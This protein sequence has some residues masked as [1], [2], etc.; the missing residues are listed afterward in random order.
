MKEATG[1]VVSLAAFGAFC[2]GVAHA[3]DSADDMASVFQ[4]WDPSLSG[5]I[6]K[7]QLR[8]ILKEFGEGLTE[9]E[10]QYA[11]DVIAGPGDRVD[12]VKFCHKCANPNAQILHTYIHPEV[13]VSAMPKP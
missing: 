9:Q 5:F 13:H 1:D 4:M 8:H 6:T 3:E 7:R 2:E 10:I 11:A 12:Y